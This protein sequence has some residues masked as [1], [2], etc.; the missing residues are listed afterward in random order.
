MVYFCATYLAY[1]LKMDYLNKTRRILAAKYVT[2]CVYVQPTRERV[3]ASA[4]LRGR[5][6]NV[7]T[8]PRNYA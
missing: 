4:G 7:I 2:F 8:N 3:G 1:L 6:V 5:E